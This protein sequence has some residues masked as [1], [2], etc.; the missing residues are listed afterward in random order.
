MF[1]QGTHSCDLLPLM[2]HGPS[3]YIRGCDCLITGR[4]GWGPPL[5]RPSPLIHAVRNSK[6]PEPIRG[7]RGV[8]SCILLRGL[9]QGQR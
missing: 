7:E 5:P 4:L 1:D 8:E 9:S 6:S 2:H 3:P